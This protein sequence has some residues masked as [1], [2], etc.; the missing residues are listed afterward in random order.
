MRRWTQA[1]YDALK[2]TE[3]GYELGSGD[4]R[5][6]DFKGRHDVIIGPHSL[7]GDNVRLGVGCRIGDHTDIGAQFE[8]QGRLVVGE[9][10][11]FGEHAHI[12]EY[13]VIG[14][15]TCFAFGVQICGGATLGENVQLPEKCGY[16]FSRQALGAN[17][18]SL[19]RLYPVAGRTICAFEADYREKRQPVAVMQDRLYT[20]EEFE[21][22][23][24]RLLAM[25]RKDSNPRHL[26]D[27]QDLHAAA[28]FIKDHFARHTACA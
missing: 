19:I 13:A 3:N 15:E 23:T 25:A 2:R 22:R 28:L 9:H 5:K 26:L 21:E 16:L 20:L 10:C 4:F 6:I 7:L 12:D 14:R 18:K 24:A 11:H 27:A 8:D 17:G 1:D